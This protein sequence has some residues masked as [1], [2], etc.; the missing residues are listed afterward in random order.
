MVLVTKDSIVIKTTGNVQTWH[1]SQEGFERISKIIANEDWEALATECT[2]AKKAEALGMEI[3]NDTLMEPSPQGVKEAHPVKTKHLC[4]YP[5]SVLRAFENRCKANPEP[6][7]A[8]ELLDF[9]DHYGLPLTRHGTFLAWK[10]VR[11]DYTDH[12]SGKVRN[13]PGDAPRM[14]RKDCDKD[15]NNPCGPGF[16]VA[17]YGFASTYHCGQRLVICEVDPYNVTSV[18]S[19]HCFKKLRCCRYKVLREIANQG[20]GPEGE[21]RAAQLILG[22]AGNDRP[23]SVG[24]SPSHVKLLK[25]KKQAPKAAPAKKDILAYALGLKASKKG[26]QYTAAMVESKFPKVGLKTLRAVL[27]DPKNPSRI[28]Q[29]Q[30]AILTKILKA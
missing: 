8:A 17:T 18:P 30:R 11:A 4:E 25:T 15:R 20:S 13:K 22:M 6:Q 3:H 28:N 29:A 16:H 23:K 12:H 7:A 26:D 14:D 2:P 1:Q 9:L 24:P 21:L 19:D 27:K 10:S 5:L